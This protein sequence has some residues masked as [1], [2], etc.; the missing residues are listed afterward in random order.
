MDAINIIVLSRSWY[1]HG[2]PYSIEWSFHRTSSSI[3][4]F[5][6]SAHPLGKVTRVLLCA[7][8]TCGPIMVRI[9]SVLSSMASSRSCSESSFRDS[10]ILPLVTTLGHPLR[11]GTVPG[12]SLLLACG[13]L[14]Q[15][16]RGFSWVFRSATNY[17]VVL[18]Y[19][20]W[21]AHSL[22]TLAISRA[23][24]WTLGLS[25]RGPWLVLSMVAS[26]RR[27]WC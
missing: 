1:V 7:L 27:L 8:T 15:V 21:V 9:R 26:L 20:C 14:S 12:F 4:V 11:G 25:S 16:G 13:V 3:L 23:K 10:L 17:L 22:M 18:G 5:V 6:L 19:T 2:P 24:G